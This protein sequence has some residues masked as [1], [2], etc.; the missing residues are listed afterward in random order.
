MMKDISNTRKILK[1]W[2]YEEI[3][4]ETRDYVGK[5][6][7]INANN[8]LSRQYHEIKEETIRVISGDLLVEVGSSAD[9]I[10]KI[11]MKAGESFHVKPKTVH[12]FCAIDTDVQLVEVSTPHLDDVVRI[13]DDYKR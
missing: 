4:A 7:Y 3:W 12:R 5:I 13:E 8:R 1:P 2:G 9:R 6:I 11:Y 10:E